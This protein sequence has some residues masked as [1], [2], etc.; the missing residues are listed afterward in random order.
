AALYDKAYEA[1]SASSGEAGR[2]TTNGSARTQPPGRILLGTGVERLDAG[3][4]TTTDG[5]RLEAD[6]VICALPVERVNRCIAEDVRTA[7]PRFGPLDEFA[8]S[9]ILGVH[10][11]FD[12][13]VMD[14]PHAVLVERPTQWLFRKDQGGTRVHAVISAAE[15]WMDLSEPQIAERVLA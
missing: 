7:D 10:L 1:L 4:V 5:D 8:H 6:R 15:E 9:P 2:F 14:R 3:S 11:A 13:P 12:R